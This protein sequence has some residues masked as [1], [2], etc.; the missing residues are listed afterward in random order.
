MK[1]QIKYLNIKTS[2]GVETV[3][4]LNRNDFNN[5]KEFRKEIK[6]LVNEYRIAG[7]NVY[8]SQRSCN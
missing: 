6:R 3:D 4:Q 5:S 8:V 1:E 7:M 2:Q